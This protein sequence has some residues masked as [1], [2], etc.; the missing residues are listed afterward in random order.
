MQFTI[1]WLDGTDPDAPARRQAVRDKHIALWDELLK[2]WNMWYGAAVWDDDN[3]MIGSILIYDFADEDEIPGSL[4][5][6]KSFLRI[7]KNLLKFIIMKKLFSIFCMILLLASCSNQKIQNKAPFTDADSTVDVKNDTKCN[8]SKRKILQELSTPDNSYWYYEWFYDKRIDDIF[9]STKTNSCLF[10]Y[11][12]V[13]VK[14][15]IAEIGH[16]DSLYSNLIDYS[17]KETL[18]DGFN[19]P[20]ILFDTCDWEYDYDC[21]Y[22]KSFESLLTIYR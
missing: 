12:F 7:E 3:N 1:I 9:Y 6:Q 5:G 8:L 20:K 2:S 19:F 4:I 21:N 16:C 22:K 10:I 18:I 17:T 14:C 15:S 11:S 13:A